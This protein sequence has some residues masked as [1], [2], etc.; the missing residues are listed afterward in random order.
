MSDLERD[1]C[2][3]L[4]AAR[5]PQ[6]VTEYQFHPERRWR[7]DVAWPVYK[8]AVELEGGV[9]SRGRHTRGQGFI[10]DCDKYN[11]AALMDWKVLRFTRKHVDDLTA[12]DTTREAIER[13][14]K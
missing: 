7:F 8:L 14:R 12:L 5:V 9:W 4:A 10:N 11:A 2:F 3:Q 13:F 1:F 6:F